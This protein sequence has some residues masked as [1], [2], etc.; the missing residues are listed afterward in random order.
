VVVWNDYIIV[1]SFDQINNISIYDYNS[2]LPV[3]YVSPH[4]DVIYAMVVDHDRLVCGSYDGSC[5][6]WKF[7]PAQKDGQEKESTNMEVDH[8][9]NN[10]SSNT[11]MINKQFVCETVLKTYPVRSLCWF[12]NYLVIGQ[13]NG[14]LVV[15]HCS[16]QIRI[17]I[18]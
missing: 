9:N 17:P 12:G 11:N 14:H 16:S 8:N 1:G 3:V 7:V 10:V 15:Y 6:V 18:E 13:E 4:R 5:S 2:K